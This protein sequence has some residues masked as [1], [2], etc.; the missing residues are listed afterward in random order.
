M[1]S[2]DDTNEER[3]N[4]HWRN[5]MRPVMFFKLDARA[6]MPFAVLLFYARLTTLIVAIITTTVFVLLE[7]R[8]LTFD[9]SLRSFRKWLLGQSRPAWISYHRRKMV[10]YG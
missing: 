2:L 5:S 6:A 3:A 4:W 7:R 1:G 10:D 8:G 9:A